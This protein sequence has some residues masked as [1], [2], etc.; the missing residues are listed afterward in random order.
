MVVGHV[1]TV[2]IIV[3]NLIVHYRNAFLAAD[4]DGTGTVDFKEF[5]EFTW[6]RKRSV[7][8]S[9]NTV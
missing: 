4:R 1:P 6:E 5:V 8:V 9:V 3:R 2:H 7:R